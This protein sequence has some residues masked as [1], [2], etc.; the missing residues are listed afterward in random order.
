MAWALLGFAQWYLSVSTII[1]QLSQA[2][3][4]GGAPA[5]VRGEGLS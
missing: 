1:N 2:R 4:A 3:P 5:G